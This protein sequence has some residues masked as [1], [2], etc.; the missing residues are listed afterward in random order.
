MAYT[1]ELKTEMESDLVQVVCG[2]DTYSIPA[3]KLAAKSQFFARALEVP[4]MEKMERKV[5]IKEISSKIFERVV[6]YIKDGSFDFDVET[7]ASESLEVSDR[8][9]ME[10]LKEELCNNIKENLDPENAKAMATLAWRFNAN[11]LFQSALEFMTK[12]NHK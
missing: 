3:N 9:D 2:K 10:K 7:E 5:I 11:Q 8:L 4:M 12:V 6:K 1:A